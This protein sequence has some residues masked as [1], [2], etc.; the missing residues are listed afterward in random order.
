MAVLNLLVCACRRGVSSLFPA[1]DL[2]VDFKSVMN[3]YSSTSVFGFSNSV[4]LTR[5]SLNQYEPGI[6]V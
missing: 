3:T 1:E 4:V 5:C 2:E 6:R